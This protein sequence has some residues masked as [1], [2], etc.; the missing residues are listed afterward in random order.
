MIHVLYV[1]MYVFMYTDVSYTKLCNNVTHN[2]NV[3]MYIHSNCFTVN[4]PSNI[5]HSGVGTVGPHTF[6]KLDFGPHT[7]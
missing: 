3:H 1:S 6:K 5:V 4:P 2:F 7:F